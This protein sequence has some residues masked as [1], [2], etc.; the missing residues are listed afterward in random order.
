MNWELYS[1]GGMLTS[2]ALTVVVVFLRLEIR[3]LREAVQKMSP[4][5]VSDT[6]EKHTEAHRLTSQ[7]VKHLEQDL[8][9]LEGRFEKL[10]E[11]GPYR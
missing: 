4:P 2:F 1:M 7:I 5:D 9:R 10:T 6:V 3:A 11:G 8:S